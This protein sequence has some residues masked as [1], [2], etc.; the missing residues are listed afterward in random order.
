MKVILLKD[1][2]NLGRMGDVKEVAAGYARNYLLRQG[3]AAPA[4]GNQL[5]Q[6]QALQ[7]RR[8]KEDALRATEAQQLAQRLGQLEITIPA[9]VGE[10]GRLFGSITNQNV[11]EALKEQH[12]LEVDR[13]N[14][15][16]D[17]SIRSTG[18]YIVHVRLSSDAQAELKMHV[19]DEATGAATPT[20]D[21]AASAASTATVV[22]A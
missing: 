6:L 19:V 12:G 14:V 3:M 18:D 22:N 13:R 7:A 11:V 9:R 4:T 5:K 17:E 15:E 16:L 20:P 2:D 10:Q 21:A 8:A 1:V